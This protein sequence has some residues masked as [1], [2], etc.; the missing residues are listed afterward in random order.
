MHIYLMM[1]LMVLFVVAVAYFAKSSVME[2]EQRADTDSVT[3]GP[4]TLV[5]VRWA[6]LLPAEQPAAICCLELKE[7]TRK[8]L[9]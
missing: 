4:E 3:A 1:I 5:A 2:F 9:G 8:G 6:E 7:Y